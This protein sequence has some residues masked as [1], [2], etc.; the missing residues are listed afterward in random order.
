MKKSL[1]IVSIFA[2]LFFL[3]FVCKPIMCC[4]PN[5]TH[6]TL[7][8]GFMMSFVGICTTFIVGYQIYI[9]ID[10]K[11][12][13]KKAE[14]VIN[15]LCN[16]KAEFKKAYL[17][18]IYYNSYTIGQIRFMMA[19]QSGEKKS[20]A[21]SALRAYTKAM[22]YAAKGGHNFSETYDALKDKIEICI[23][24]IVS[25]SCDE[26]INSSKIK[27]Q[28]QDAFKE[29][30]DTTF[31]NYDDRIAKNDYKKMMQESWFDKI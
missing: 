14:T 3:A 30:E 28:I 13:I 17:E 5:S 16:E 4:V 9:S 27:L 15:D 23:N 29:I 12:R 7:D 10:Y 11:E 1:F 24:I 18:N 19:E 20:Y 8:T 2:I 31:N 21:W 6:F 26:H 22:M 25:G